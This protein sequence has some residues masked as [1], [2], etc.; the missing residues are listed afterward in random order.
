SDFKLL[1]FDRWGGEIFES[2]DILN[3]WDGKKDGKLC[4]GGVYVY[5][6]AFRLDGVPGVEGANVEV[7]TVML[8][9]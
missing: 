9:R 1:I 5:R 6:I 8:V 7:G 2:T 3:G 4:P